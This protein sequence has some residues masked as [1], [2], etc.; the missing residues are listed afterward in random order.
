MKKIFIDCG[1]HKGESSWRWN[2]KHPSYSIYAF[3]PNPYIK[4]KLPEGS[5]LYREAV[6]V[7]DCEMD[8]YLMKDRCAEGC[9]LIKDKVNVLKD[10][11]IK[12]PAIDFSWW[13]DTLLDDLKENPKIIVKMDI[14]GAEYD[15]LEKMIFDET[16][17]CVNKLFVEWHQ[18]KARIEKGRH[19]ALVA[20]LKA[21]PML[22]LYKEFSKS[23]F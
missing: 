10:N 22:R 11:F 16:I 21:V 19:D 8:F 23:N 17:T 4:I 15:V 13:L 2:Q 5:M 12:V 6:W 7:A 3:E 14:E 18:V 1:A 9:S 20:K